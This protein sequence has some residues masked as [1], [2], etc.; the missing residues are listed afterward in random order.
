[1]SAQPKFQSSPAR[2]HRV[3]VGVLLTIA[4]ITA[5]M[6]IFATW[7]KRQALDTDN[8]TNTSGRLL[9]D[10][11][12]QDAVGAYLVNELFT[13]VDVA[14][15]LQSALPQQAQALAGP[16]AGGLRELANRAAPQLLARPRVQEAWRKAN[17]TAHRE[18]LRILNG[19]TPLV[20]TDRGQVVLDLH[21]LVDQLA[22][23]IGIEPQV[24][25]ARA[26]LQGAA[27][28]Q[29][30]GVAQQRLGITLPQS[31]G[32]L[33]V[34]RSDQLRTAQNLA[35]AVRGLSI[36]FTA[37]SLG[38]FAI[39]IWVAR[40]W[41]RV[42]LRSTGW[43]F[44]GVGVFILLASRVG[45]NQ[46]VD[47]L[48][49]A[50]SIRPAVHSAWAIGTS[51]LHAIA[52]AVLV[53]GLLVVLAAWLAGPTRSA[54]AVRRALAPTL[55]EHVAVTYSV[56][57]GVYLLVLLWGPTPALRH[58]VPILLIA[59]L[60]AVGIELL[61]RQAAREYPDARAG[62][63]LRAFRAWRAARSA[64]ARGASPGNGLQLE[65][66]ERLASLHDSGAL[67][68]D[69]YKDQKVVLLGAVGHHGNSVGEDPR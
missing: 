4:V 13:N 39:A 54:G 14:G 63:S 11:Q 41:R 15:E 49:R 56:A 36:V 19:G 62:D 27:G 30:R 5:F 55:R 68:D 48:V 43:C 17:R 2:P 18:L 22:T 53:Y 10:P 33:E 51:L 7:V 46:I 64:P 1:M 16:A 29:A 3:T 61:R 28:N 67:T 35:K 20:S 66:M 57:G 25:A 44:V 12:I 34:L 26:K 38:L 31:A 60:L 9:S 69:E 8:W 45:G 23:T 37:V 52:V 65:Q 6:A 42:A 50:E 21:A 59:A 32:R 47:R 40:G 58:I 24:A